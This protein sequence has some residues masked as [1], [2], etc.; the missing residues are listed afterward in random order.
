MN[1][2]KPQDYIA[3][4]A[5]KLIEQGEKLLEGKFKDETGFDTFELLVD[6]QEHQKWAASCRLLSHQLGPFAAAWQQSLLSMSQ[7]NR[8]IGVLSKLGALRSICECIE[9]GRLASFEDLVFAEALANLLEQGEHLLERSFFLPAAVI[10]RAVLEERLR[11][12][13]EQQNALPDKSRPTIADFNQALYGTKA[14]DKIT[15]KQVDALAAIGNAAAHLT[16]EFDPT[17]VK[18]MHSGLLSFLS[19]FPDNPVPTS[20]S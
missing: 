4:F 3:S 13:C 18:D 9:D 2:N 11:R 7:G 19:R 20:N 6:F 1:M 15:M 8:E 10:F 5:K 14:Y 16:G 12:L 17:T